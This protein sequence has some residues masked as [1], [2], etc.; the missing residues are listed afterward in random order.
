MGEDSSTHIPP[1]PQD[2]QI[3]YLLHKYIW[4]QGEGHSPVLKCHW[5]H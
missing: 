3:Q 1:N 4:G 5:N 2:T